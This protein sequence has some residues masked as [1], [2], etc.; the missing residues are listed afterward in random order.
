MRG[1]Y[2]ADFVYS[3]KTALTVNE[4]AIESKSG[5]KSDSVWSDWMPLAAAPTIV[6]KWYLGPWV[7]KLSA[8]EIKPA[9]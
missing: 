5:S 6:A 2:S 8:I 7:L 4:A 1:A 9:E 3:G